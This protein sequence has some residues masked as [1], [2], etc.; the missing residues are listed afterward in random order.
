M[1]IEVSLM[2][3]RMKLKHDHFARIS[4]EIKVCKGMCETD[5]NHTHASLIQ[6]RQFMIKSARK[7]VVEPP[8]MVGLWFCSAAFMTSLAPNHVFFSCH[9]ALCT[10][11][12]RSS[13][14]KKDLVPERVIIEKPYIFTGSVLGPQADWSTEGEATRS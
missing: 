4:L 3:K 10:S 8:M 13:Q 1:F 5:S 6:K 12:F 11:P 2:E 9:L 7:L 14:K